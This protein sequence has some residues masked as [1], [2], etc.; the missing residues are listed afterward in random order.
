MLLIN[1]KLAIHFRR[2]SASKNKRFKGILI[3]ISNSYLNIQSV[4]GY[5]CKSGTV[6]FAWRV[7]GND[8]HSPCKQTFCRLTNVL[9]LYFPI[10][11]CLG[12]EYLIL[13][14]P[15]SVREPRR[16]VKRRNC[17]WCPGV[18]TQP[19]LKRKC[20]TPRPSML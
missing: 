6:I 7:T 1:K 3:L 5:R 20:S 19:R 13:S 12:M 4:Q 10:L 11:L 17:S 2:E 14:T 15:T 8:A 16:P 18:L 9:I